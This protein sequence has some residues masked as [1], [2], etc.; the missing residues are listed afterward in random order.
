MIKKELFQN[1]KDLRG[2]GNICGDGACLFQNPEYQKT[3]RD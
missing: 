3:V 1:E 2:K